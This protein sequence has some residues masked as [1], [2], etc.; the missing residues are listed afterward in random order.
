MLSGLLDSHH[1]LGECVLARMC[2]EALSQDVL[3]IS[4]FFLL[5]L[6]GDVTGDA[7]ISFH[8]VGELIYLPGPRLSV[9]DGHSAISDRHRGE[10][11]KSEVMFTIPGAPRSWLDVVTLF[12]VFLSSLQKVAMG[13]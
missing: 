4:A 5:S 1:R 11:T 12:T 7:S 8:N 2:T 6:V 3:T 13:K 9:V 10:V